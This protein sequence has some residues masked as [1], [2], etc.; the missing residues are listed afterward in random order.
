MV[1]KP[2]RGRK[3]FRKEF[4]RQLKYAIAA[5]VGFLIAYAWKEAIFN[6]AEQVMEKIINTGKVAISNIST[7]IFI[8]IIGVIIIIIS[9]RLLRDK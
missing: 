5:G 6:S 3:S 9:S 4:K 7:S 1:F 8:T 2:K